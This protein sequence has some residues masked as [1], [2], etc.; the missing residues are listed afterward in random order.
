MEK[1]YA[2]V[3]SPEKLGWK[4]YVIARHGH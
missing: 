1:G 2:P 3:E 4:A